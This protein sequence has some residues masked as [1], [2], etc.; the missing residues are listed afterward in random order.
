MRMIEPQ[1]N[2]MLRAT[3]NHMFSRMTVYLFNKL[4]ET[5]MEAVVDGRL[6]HHPSVDFE[7]VNSTMFE[8]WVKKEIRYHD[9]TELR[10]EREV[11]IFIQVFR[12]MFNS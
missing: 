6:E 10:D 5:V 9:L 7:F 8:D 11:K 1:Q 3:S 2:G 12:D 4:K